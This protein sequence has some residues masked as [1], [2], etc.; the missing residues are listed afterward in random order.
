MDLL[1]Q[2]VSDGSRA[3]LARICA[4]HHCTG[5][6][7]IELRAGT[8]SSSCS[9]SPNMDCRHLAVFESSIL[10][11][12]RRGT[13]RTVCS[14]AFWWSA[15]LWSM[16]STILFNELSS[17]NR[18][19]GV[20]SIHWPPS[21]LADDEFCRLAPSELY[22]FFHFPTWSRAFV[23]IYT[24]AECH[25]V[26]K[27][28]RHKSSMASSSEESNLPPWQGRARPFLVLTVGHVPKQLLE[29][30]GFPRVLWCCG[31]GLQLSA[32]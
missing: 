7:L 22:S 11:L 12:P 8:V 4:K 1:F 15:V 6:S 17:A 31:V 30:T 14:F 26:E 32:L 29:E 3:K 13:K 9:T 23:K 27:S 20:G 24:A 16:G 25:N 2:N 28:A 19:D 10:N 18:K 21:T 5:P